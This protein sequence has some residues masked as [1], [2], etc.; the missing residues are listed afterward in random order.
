M[1]SDWAETKPWELNI[2]GICTSGFCNSVHF[3]IPGLLIGWDI[4]LLLPRN[5]WDFPETNAEID[6]LQCQ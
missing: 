2:S 5:Y 3:L 6:Y 4:T 1:R